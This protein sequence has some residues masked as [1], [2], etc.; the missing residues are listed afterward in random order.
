MNLRS[1]I[2]TL[3]VVFI[4]VSVGWGVETDKIKQSCSSDVDFKN[5]AE[6]LKKTEALTTLELSV[7]QITGSG[8]EER[9]FSVIDYANLSFKKI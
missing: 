7:L 1:I 2:F 6:Q 3:V 4:S 9:F 5:F 8:A